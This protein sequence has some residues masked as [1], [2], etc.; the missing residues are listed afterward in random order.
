MIKRKSAGR[1]TSGQS[2]Q[3]G[4]EPLEAR[5]MLTVTIASY[6]TIEFETE[7]TP[8]SPPPGDV[9]GKSQI[10]DM[11]HDNVSDFVVALQ[12]Q[13]AMAVALYTDSGFE[14]QSDRLILPAVAGDFVMNDIN[15][16]GLADLVMS[17]GGQTYVMTSESLWPWR[18]QPVQV[19]DWYYSMQLVD[20]NQDGQLDLLGLNQ[21]L[22]VLFGRPDGTFDSATEYSV[23]APIEHFQLTDMDQDND[24]D[25]VVQTPTS[26]VV[27]RNE[28][29]FF[30]SQLQELERHYNIALA[31]FTGD[32]IVDLAAY[33]TDDSLWIYA[34]D[35]TGEFEDEGTPN[36]LWGKPGTMIPCHLNDDGV[37]DLVY[38][39]EWVSHHP[40]GGSDGWAVLLSNGR[41]GFHPSTRVEIS[42]AYDL[43]VVDVNQDQL[44]DVIVRLRSQVHYY[45]YLRKNSD[46][47]DVVYLG[48]GGDV[49]TSTIGYINDDQVP[50]IVFTRDDSV[51]VVYGDTNGFGPDRFDII[52]V[53]AESFVIGRFADS[54]DVTLIVTTRT[55][56]G[57]TDFL[58]YRTDQEGKFARFDS[59]QLVGTWTLEKAIDLDGDGIDELVATEDLQRVLLDVDE[60]GI[61]RNRAIGFRDFS[62]L[63]ELDLTTPDFDADGLADAAQLNMTYVRREDGSLGEL[64]EI[65]GTPIAYPDLNSDGRSDVIALYRYQRDRYFYNVYLSSGDNVVPVG[66]FE[67]LGWRSE[68]FNVLQTDFDQDGI[69][70]AYLIGSAN[71]LISLRWQDGQIR[72][73]TLHLPHEINPLAHARDINLDGNLDLV[74]TSQL[75]GV[76]V[77]YGQARTNSGDVNQDG[78]INI[79]DIDLI[80]AAVYDSPSNPD[81]LDRMDLNRDQQITATDVDILL[82]DILNTVAGDVNLDGKFDSADLVQIFQASEYEDNV[83]GNSKWSEGDWNCDGDFSTADLVYVFQKGTYSRAALG[84]G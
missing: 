21:E 24:P 58:R 32:G 5:H 18:V 39:F 61:R 44:L 41:G 74:G 29:G 45:V 48:P 83:T 26:V 19:L 4:F 82:S 62:I 25:L 67:I 10:I 28:Q 73:S 57:S 56:F 75:G 51:V 64:A 72:L 43:Q 46:T 6:P 84:N 55:V 7:T 27:L 71:Q 2:P 47:S 50:D 60:T 80:C 1:S 23:G 35:G 36:L 77:L 52:P 78:S 76:F 3:L 20:V 69:E 13:A 66:E 42:P 31:D 9:L 16:D 34:G 81:E 53:K 22:F 33:G 11:N 59:S 8:I 12:N 79:E 54:N 49:T 14:F 65:S 70:E 30:E 38:V 15:H 63:R 17:G 40:L 37:M 68:K